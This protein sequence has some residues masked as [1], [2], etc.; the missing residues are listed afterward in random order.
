M[1][2]ETMTIRELVRAIRARRACRHISTRS[3]LLHD[4]MVTVVTCL[5]CEQR[6]QLDAFDLMTGL[7]WGVR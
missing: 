4:P 1:I 2:T 6:V 3:F 7:R 5:D